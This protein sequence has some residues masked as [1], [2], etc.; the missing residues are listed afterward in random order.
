MARETAGLDW[1]GPKLT[2]LVENLEKSKLQLHVCGDA[3]MK[4]CEMMVNERKEIP[5]GV[6][7][8][9]AF[10]RN[11]L[12]LINGCT[13]PKLELLATLIVSELPSLSVNKWIWMK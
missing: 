1:T 4:A 8:G 2:F 10:A 9:V 3:S 6:R 7:T 11:R 12:A 5:K 13:V